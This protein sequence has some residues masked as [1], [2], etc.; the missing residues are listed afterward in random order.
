MSDENYEIAEIYALYTKPDLIV[1][2]APNRDL[3]KA[4]WDNLPEHVRHLA[5]G[6][7]VYELFDEGE[8][9]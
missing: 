4:E 1:E 3:T 9:A 6:S 7:G 8:Q 5:L 2:G